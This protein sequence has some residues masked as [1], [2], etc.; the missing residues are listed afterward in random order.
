MP[1]SSTHLRP[2]GEISAWTGSEP[3]A[4]TA[5]VLLPPRTWR[6]LADLYSALHVLPR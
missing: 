5:Y 3:P 2:P 1:L 6:L 4:G